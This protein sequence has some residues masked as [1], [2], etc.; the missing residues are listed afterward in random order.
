M[1]MPLYIYKTKDGLRVPGVTTVI[2]GNLGWNKQAL[3]YWAWNEGIE[4]RNSFV[5]PLARLLILE[6]LPT[7]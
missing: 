7:P 6:P 1:T 5:K 4:G 2:G 3:M